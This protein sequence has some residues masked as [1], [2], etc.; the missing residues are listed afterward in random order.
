MM[1]GWFSRTAHVEVQLHAQN[2]CVHELVAKTDSSHRAE[3]EVIPC[4]RRRG[5]W[6]MKLGGHPKKSKHPHRRTLLPCL[7]FFYPV[8]PL[9]LSAQ[10]S[11]S[12][13]GR[14]TVPTHRRSALQ[15][16]HHIELSLFSDRVPSAEALGLGAS[17]GFQKWGFCLGIVDWFSH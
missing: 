16:Q 3:G 14:L 10:G 17:C 7:V 12:A 8:S 9:S 13:W 2:M 11:D 6:E 4:P 15:H 5:R 1:N